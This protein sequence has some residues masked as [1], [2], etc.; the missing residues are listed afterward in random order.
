MA[1]ENVRLQIRYRSQGKDTRPKVERTFII[2]L[3]CSEVNFITCHRDAGTERAGRR[4]PSQ[5]L[6]DQLTLC[7]LGGADY[8]PNSTYYSPPPQIFRPPDIPN[9]YWGQTRH[10][11]QILAPNNTKILSKEHSTYLQKLA[12]ISIKFGAGQVQLLI[13]YWFNIWNAWFKGIS[14]FRYKILENWGTWRSQVWTKNR[15]N[16]AGHLSKLALCQAEI[17]LF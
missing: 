12:W 3:A 10:T 17:L 1:F 2:L 11:F 16:W 7:Q 14:P 4:T 13:Y 15:R 9:M 5:I 8:T 6:A